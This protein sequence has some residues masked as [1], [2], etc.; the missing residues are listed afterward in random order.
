MSRVDKSTGQSVD[1]FATNAMYLPRCYVIT[2]IKGA[3]VQG[4]IDLTSYVSTR[5]AL[6]YS[7]HN[8]A[9]SIRI[10]TDSAYDDLIP[11]CFID[12]TFNGTCS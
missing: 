6:S 10:D 7:S 5:L 3:V 4:V 9:L 12:V 8:C 11:G 1:Y 2:G